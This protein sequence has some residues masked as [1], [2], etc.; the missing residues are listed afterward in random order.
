VK[1]GKPTLAAGM[2][3]IRASASRA[4]VNLKQITLI[5]GQGSA[6]NKIAP[7]AQV[8]L[9][10]HIAG[11][12]Y[13]K[14]FRDALPIKGVDGLPEDPERD[15]ATKH[16][17]NKNGVTGAED[18]KGRIEVQ[19]MALAG[20]VDTEGKGLAFDLVAN[21]IPI[22]GPD[23]KPSQEPEAIGK[24]FQNFPPLEGITTQLYLSQR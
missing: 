10:R 13:A 11:Q 24:A 23:G 6:G 21:S 4:G 18:D 16:V 17:S 1:A 9:L 20:Y 8:Q 12:P 3:E 15:P 7:R 2:D 19:A 14:A 5:D 22:I